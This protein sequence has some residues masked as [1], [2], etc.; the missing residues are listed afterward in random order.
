M[1]WVIALSGA[2]WILIGAVVVGVWGPKPSASPARIEV[3]EAKEDPG[4]GRCRHLGEA[5]KDDATCRMVWASAR[6]HFFGGDRP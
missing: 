2:A 1:R 3:A 6:S 5:A 4:L